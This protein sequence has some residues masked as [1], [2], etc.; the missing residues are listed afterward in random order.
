[1]RS[2][3]ELLVIV[4]LITYPTVACA[5]QK[6]EPRFSPD[7]AVLAS[8]EEDCTAVLWDVALGKRIAILYADEPPWSPM[9]QSACHV[10]L[11]F[12]PN[13]KLLATQR[14]YGQVILWDA[15]SGHKLATFGGTGDDG[16]SLIFSRDS[17]LIVSVI[18]AKASSHKDA[19]TNGI[20]V[21]DVVTQK[22]LL[23]VREDQKKEF[24]EVVLSPDGKTV[25][26]LAG[27]E[28]GSQLELSTDR[29]I[30]DRIKLWDIQRG[31]ELVTLK[32]ESAKFS[33]DGKF[34][35]YRD[36][37][38]AAVWD[39]GAGKLCAL[40]IIRGPVNFSPNRAIL[41]EGQDYCAV[42]WDLDTGNK[43][44]EF[45]DPQSGAGRELSSRWHNVRV[46]FS[47]GGN[48]L[49]TQRTYGPIE[50]WNSKDGL[51]LATL[52]GAFKDLIS[53]QFSADSRLLLSVGDASRSVD[54]WPSI[55][56]VWEV[57]TQKELFNVDRGN[58][59][60]FK[61]V[62]F[63]PD[64]KMIMAYIGERLR[65]AGK[66]RI[67]GI[68]LWDI[69][70]AEELATLKA[71]SATSA[72][73]SPD[74]RLLLITDPALGA[75]VLDIKAR[76]MRTVGHVTSS[77]QA[78]DISVDNVAESAGDNKWNW[79]IFLKGNKQDLDDI[80]CVEYKLHPTFPNPVRLVCEP[81]DPKRPF[82]LSVTGWGTF[83]V[84]IRV[85]MKDRRQQNLRH[86]LKF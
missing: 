82:G 20:S 13:G 48:L 36:P 66:Y 38:G 3:A 61:R 32:G 42:A 17:R 45:C 22:E 57:G 27:S 73:F 14:T 84:S 43:V 9:T 55:M 62:A 40:P 34:L 39:I 12:S 85:F 49:A 86:Q 83:P 35:L 24:N 68:T 70:R 58:N 16:V 74:G 7:G 29:Y 64:G 26:A 4:L 23:N 15:Q 8:P 2:A 21:W 53:L 33:P 6:G 28:I 69:D 47:P 46:S 72:S 60:G 76:K 44:A 65:V 54:S 78:E 67:N 77:Q 10:V 50:L 37:R 71:S 41:I 18:E 31:R 59:A 80:K 30:T 5:V 11:S 63:S 79:T 52:R 56:T 51:K 81:G 75:R 19:R 1:M 25:M